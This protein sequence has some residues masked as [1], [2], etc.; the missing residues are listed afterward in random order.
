MI[1]VPGVGLPDNHP[2]S[3]MFRF[4]RT[5]VVCAG[6]LTQSPHGRM[7]AI[8]S[9]TGV[10][11]PSTPLLVTLPCL[12]GPHRL[13]HAPQANTRTAHKLVA[14]GMCAVTDTV[15]EEFEPSSP[16][17]EGA[18]LYQCVHGSWI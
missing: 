7:Q 2:L 6:T 17:A 3:K 4:I 14:V 13:L 1:R 11:A 10:R 8:L 18:T 16:H 15:L 5:Y 12:Y 9:P